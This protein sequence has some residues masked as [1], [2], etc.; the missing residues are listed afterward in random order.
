MEDTE[1][2]DVEIN[3]EDGEDAKRESDAQETVQTWLSLDEFDR[4]CCMDAFCREKLFGPTVPDET[5][6]FG[7]NEDQ[8]YRNVEVIRIPRRNICFSGS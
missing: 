7:S 2:S 6:F 5:H 4:D 3:V 8:L 1:C